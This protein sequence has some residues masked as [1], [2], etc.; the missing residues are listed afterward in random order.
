MLR[1]RTTE[2]VLP[3]QNDDTALQYSYSTVV[4][5]AGGV[6]PTDR[7]SEAEKYRIKIW[8]KINAFEKISIES[9]DSIFYFLLSLLFS[10]LTPTH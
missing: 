9:T 7:P 3:K 1:P 8:K 5:D 6:R 4:D 10:S 2:Y